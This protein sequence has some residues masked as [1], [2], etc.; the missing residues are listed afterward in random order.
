MRHL[1]ARGRLV[2]GGGGGAGLPI[3]LAVTGPGGGPRGAHERRAKRGPWSSKLQ[4]GTQGLGGGVWRRERVVLLRLAGCPWH[5]GQLT[6]A[7]GRWFKLSGGGQQGRLPPLPGHRGQYGGRYGVGRAVSVA[8]RVVFG[9]VRASCG[10]GNTA[11]EDWFEI[12]PF[13]AGWVGAAVLSFSVRARAEGAY[14]GV[15][16]AGF[17]MAQS[18]AVIALFGGGRGI[19]S[20]DNVVAAKDGYCGEVG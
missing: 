1:P 10:R 13:G 11:V 3:R 16:A 6:V 4:G 8:C 9:T 7:G 18:P 17:D 2:S 14:S 19:G 20:F 15:S 5:L 12:A